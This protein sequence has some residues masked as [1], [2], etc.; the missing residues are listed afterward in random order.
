MK[1][2]KPHE[3]VGQCA[4]SSDA[5]IKLANNTE[6]VLWAAHQRAAELAKAEPGVVSRTIFTAVHAEWRGAFLGGG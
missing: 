1:F 6:R 3:V 4:E 5:S 2:S